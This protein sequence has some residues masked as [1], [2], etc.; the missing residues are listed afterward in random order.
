MIEVQ[1]LEVTDF[2][3]GITD[4]YID[5]SPNEFE[6]LDNF[7]LRPNAK[8]I[9]RWGSTFEVDEKIPLGTF[10]LSK[11]AYLW[12]SV[13]SEDVLLTFAQKKVY[14]H[15]SSSWS[16]LQSVS[17]DPVFDMG[18]GNSIPSCSGWQGH[19]LVAN[20]DF[21]VPQK[22]FFDETSTL[23]VQSAG[24]PEVPTSG[25]SIANPSGSGSTYS[26]LFLFRNEYQVGN[27]TNLDRGPKTFYS[28]LVEGG[29]IT[30]GNSAV[31]TLPTA[32]VDDGNYDTSSF[33]V[34]IYR[35][36]TAS[37]DYF[38]VD[39]VS[40][41][42]S[43]YTDEVEDADLIIN[44]PIYSAT[45]DYAAPPRCK[46][47]HVVNEI[48]YYAHIKEEGGD[49]ERFK[50]LQS[51]PGDA[52]SV[53]PTFLEKV[54][55]EITGLSSI[56]DRPIVLCNNYI[57]RIDQFIA[58]D[59][60]G[61]M[62]IRRIDDRAGCVSNSSIV[63]THRGL[64]WA[65]EEGFFW[66]DGFKVKNISKHINETYQTLVSNSTRASRIY[67]SFDPSTERIYWSVCK[68]DGGNEVDTIF[69]LDLKFTS[70]S[71]GEQS[72]GCF[73]TLSGEDN[74]KPTATIVKDENLYRGD[75]RGY[76]FKHNRSLFS[77]PLIDSGESDLSNWHTTPI[78]Y[79]LRSSFL[80]FGTKFVRKF[81]SR[82]LISAANRTNL[83]LAIQSSNDNNRVIG[84]LKP[85]AYK[86]NITWGASLPVWGDASAGW[87][88]GGV[89]E[90]WRRFPAGGLRCQY[91]QIRLFNNSVCIITS[92][93]LGNVTVDDTAKTLTLSGSKVFPTDLENYDV[94]VSS[95]SYSKNYKILSQSSNTLVVEDTNNTLV[96]GDV[97][98]KIVGIPKDEILELN[99]YVINWAPL[100]R[101]HTP[102]IGGGSE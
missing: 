29:T 90:Q 19:L 51:I 21:S 7:F 82:I 48:G 64:F 94:Q 43:T 60:T 91:K 87:N 95:N 70:L 84:D 41:G 11:L 6:K 92:T 1:P 83:S 86:Q 96:S 36:A 97:E 26:Y 20:S 101:S 88:L 76:L 23:K 35:T 72:R 71:D 28:T 73:T 40:F 16:E 39:T 57:Y 10:R 14:T 77:D 65:G 54:E 85:I 56:F 22:I 34:E 8:P 67:G 30:T 9:V 53:P 68:E 37:D 102:Y 58:S 63:Q 75:S 32:L 38:L 66:S 62:D 46:F 15:D 44:T 24:L 99:G 25:L 59:G 78:L 12:D 93:L 52:D 49:I 47:V 98:F 81:V 61:N 17:L 33:E 27:R 80:D 5:G 13:A 50:I 89:I 55:Q 100:S 69:V 4:Y 2:S 18:D 45:V 31:I 3:G 74:F 79:N 42:T